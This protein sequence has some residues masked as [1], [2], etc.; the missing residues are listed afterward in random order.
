MLN[1]LIAE[2]VALYKAIADMKK[3]MIALGD[4]DPPKQKMIFEKYCEARNQ[5]VK[6]RQKIYLLKE[7][8]DE[9]SE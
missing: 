3:I 5:L 1:E 9:S 8:L 4:S 7:A 6:V 2:R